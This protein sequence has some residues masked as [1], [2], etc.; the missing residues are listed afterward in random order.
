M[1]NAS[2]LFFAI[3][4]VFITDASKYYTPSYTN[5]D[6]LKYSTQYQNKLISSDFHHFEAKENV[7]FGIWPDDF[8]W[9]SVEQLSRLKKEFG[10]NYLLIYQSKNRIL[11]AQKV[12]Y[13]Y[14]NILLRVVEKGMY[15]YTETK[16]FGKPY[17]YYFDEP[18]DQPK[19]ERSKL[20]SIKNYVQ[21]YSENSKFVVGLY[22][23]NCNRYA[24][25][26]DEYS[27][28]VMYSSYDYPIFPK[29][30]GC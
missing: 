2:Y 6:N 8:R 26:F 4:S 15:V 17:A 23:Y 24:P 1:A 28:F 16:N 5:N 21:A 10:F 7:I 3:L 18:L 13:N 20:V 27:D 29:D 12:G 9:D 19:L 14:S 25:P 11:N 30:N 22:K